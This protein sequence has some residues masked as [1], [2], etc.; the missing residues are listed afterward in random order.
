MNVHAECEYIPI[1][2]DLKVYYFVETYYL[3]FIQ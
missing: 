1:D 2:L 3:V